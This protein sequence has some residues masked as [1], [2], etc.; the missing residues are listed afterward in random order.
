MKPR[1]GSGRRR[2]QGMTEYIII[3]GLIALGLIVAVRH[4]KETLRVA[5]EGNDGS[6]GVA[7]GVDDVADGIGNP[8]YNPGG[9]GGSNPGGGGG[10]LNPVT[11]PNGRTVY[12][13]AS[14][15]RF[16]DANGRIPYGG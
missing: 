13:D 12:E 4:Y 3:V 8:G 15:R 1:L 14:G 9:G 5:I 7:G 11:L 2:G 10:G 16:E 6:G